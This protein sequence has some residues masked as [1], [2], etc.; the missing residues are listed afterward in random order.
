MLT[1]NSGANFTGSSSRAVPQSNLE[2]AV[3]S[4]VASVEPEI[5]RLPL[6]LFLIVIGFAL[7]AMSGR[8]EARPVEIPG[9]AEMKVVGQDAGI[10]VQISQQGNRLIVLRV[11]PGG[12]ADKVGLKAWDEIVQVEERW[13]KGMD[14]EMAI[15]LIRGDP[16]TQLNLFVQRRNL[17]DPIKLILTRE[18][19]PGAAK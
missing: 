19:L 3:A 17:P 2:L 5:M 10:G 15:S 12:A 16:G 6:S 7:V 13:F 8:L 18:M 4:P 9:H 14:F 11:L 1:K